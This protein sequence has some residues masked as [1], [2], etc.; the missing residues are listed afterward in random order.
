LMGPFGDADGGAT[1]MQSMDSCSISVE[2]DL[3]GVG[4]SIGTDA[5]G[6][7]I[8]VGRS[9][10]RTR[11]ELVGPARIGIR[12]WPTEATCSWRSSCGDA[13]AVA[14]ESRAPSCARREGARG[15][16]AAAGV[17]DPTTLP[18]P[19]QRKSCGF[20]PPRVARRRDVLS[21]NGVFN[22]SSL[23][24]NKRSATSPICLRCTVI[25]YLRLYHGVWV[26]SALSNYHG[27]N[28]GT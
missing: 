22:F 4:S 10:G 19:P 8:P 12:S 28:V 27:I 25:N 26:G 20:S 2:T 16:E 24:L 18:S 17:G 23:S 3:A 7:A 13:K 1:R 21:R 14:G 11:Q 5:A 6:A 15:S 9:S